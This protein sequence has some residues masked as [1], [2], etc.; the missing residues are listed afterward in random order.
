MNLEAMLNPE[1]IF[2][3]IMSFFESFYPEFIELYKSDEDKETF[4]DSIL[5]TLE[6][7]Y[8]Y[9]GATDRDLQAIGLTYSFGEVG[10]NECYG[11][12]KIDDSLQFEAQGDNGLNT[13]LDC[14]NQ[15]I[16]YLEGSD[17]SRQIN[18]ELRTLNLNKNRV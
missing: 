5:V 2:M 10:D 8:K 12:I 1:E 4:L 7:M 13:K 11:V 9:S 18:H 17:E 15:L 14:L 6:K 16:E 3:K